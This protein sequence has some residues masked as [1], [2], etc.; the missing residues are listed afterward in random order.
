[1][2]MATNLEVQQQGQQFRIVD[3]PSLP[4][5]PSNTDHIKVSLGGAA[6]GLALG[7]ALA[8]LL[9]TTDHCLYDE[10]DVSRRFDIPLVVSVPHLPS[11]E[12][13]RKRPWRM[14]VEW[15]AGSVLVI[16]VALAEFYVYRRG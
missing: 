8:F 9:E 15:V 4:G 6:A 13:E 10:H 1:S 14:G 5:K 11:A 16:A 3:Q 2:E 12:E 7:L